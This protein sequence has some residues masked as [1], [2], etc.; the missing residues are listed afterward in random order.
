MGKDDGY[1]L[2][3]PA[4]AVEI[5]Y[6]LGVCLKQQMYQPP[7]T[8]QYVQLKFKRFIFNTFF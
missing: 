5:G 8:M 7:Y 3:K 1:G 2:R 4:P 6:I